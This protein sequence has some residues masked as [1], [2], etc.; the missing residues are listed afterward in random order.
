MEQERTNS[1]PRIRSEYTKYGKTTHNQ[2]PESYT[3]TAGMRPWRKP[4][5]Q[6]TLRLKH[7]S[8]SIIDFNTV[9]ITART[10]HFRIFLNAPCR[11]MAVILWLRTIYLRDTFA[12]STK[13]NGDKRTLLNL[14]I[15]KV[16]HVSVI[17]LKHIYISSESMV[18]RLILCTRLENHIPRIH[19]VKFIIK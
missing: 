4:P 1:A 11:L 10:Y 17:H 15:S 18:I 14:I 19:V 8:F 2:F 3:E 12:N 16:C 7:T 6:C 13:W 5:G 9:S